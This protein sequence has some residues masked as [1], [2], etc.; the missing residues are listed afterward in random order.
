MSSEKHSHGAT[1]HQC[2]VLAIIA[3]H[4]PLTSAQVAEK[5]QELTGQNVAHNYQYIIT[6]RM[7]DKGLIR[8]AG[9]KDR[10]V[11]E[12]TIT[13]SGKK[14]LGEA[15]QLSKVLVKM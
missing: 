14:L 9:G 2:L 13:A 4:G 11:F 15:T 7:A 5:Y 8:S 6:R 1:L 10:S 12:W 3:N